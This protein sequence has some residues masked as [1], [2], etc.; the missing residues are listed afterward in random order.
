MGWYWLKRGKNTKWRGICSIF[1]Y[2]YQRHAIVFRKLLCV[3]CTMPFFSLSVPKSSSEN[4]HFLF[5]SREGKKLNY[6]HGKRSQQS[7]HKGSLNPHLI[8]LP[9]KMSANELHHRT[10]V[11]RFSERENVAAN[12][13]SLC[14]RCEV[15]KSACMQR[16]WLLG[17][18]LW[19][20]RALWFL[21]IIFSRTCSSCY[22]A[23]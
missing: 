23:N 3:S 18:N 15:D 9:W 14:N 2:N 8:H 22:F 11:V 13:F 1:L 5:S 4:S 20:R 19:K 16:G 10:N 12:T 17:E 6:S 21:F 7:F